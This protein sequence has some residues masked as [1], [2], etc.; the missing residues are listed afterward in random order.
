MPTGGEVN[1]GTRWLTADEAAS[2]LNVKKETIYAY[3]SRGRLANRRSEDGRGSMFDEAE[4]ERVALGTRQGSTRSSSDE[5][6]S[7]LT[8]ITEAGHFYR[9]QSA[10]ELADTRSWEEVAQLLWGVP[11]EISAWTPAADIAATSRD[12]VRALPN[13]ILPV[14]AI[15][16]VTSVIGALEPPEW[17]T[18]AAVIAASARRA[19]AT[20]VAG[21]PQRSGPVE[22]DCGVAPRSWL[23][24]LLWS[25]LCERQ[26]SERELQVLNGVMVVLADHDLASATVMARAAA[27]SGVNVGGIV[28]LGSDV[29]SGPV[30]GAASLAIETFLHNLES[31]E[32]VERALTMRLR[33]GEPIPGFGHSLYPDGDPRAIYALGRLRA[34][35]PQS[36]RLA[37]VEELIRMQKERGLPPPNAGFGLAALTYITGMVPG[38]GEAIFVV[39][40]AA[41][42]IA[43]AIE[44]YSAAPPPRQRSRYIGLPLAVRD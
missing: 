4:I 43:H 24:P 33:Q 11:A 26:P 6:E 42:W 25:R 23:V 30:K 21:L 44:E 39:S 35:D 3:V 10:A 9:G 8:L 22:M 32:S 28:R 41:G 14:D 34:L 29:G 31:P 19:F 27:R 15:K 12:V 16:L 36:N 17:N 2:R 20:L 7:R 40:R 5:V 38:A 37:A 18:S 13:S 1:E